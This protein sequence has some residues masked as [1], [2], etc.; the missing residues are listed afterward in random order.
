[1]KPKRSKIREILIWLINTDDENR[2]K[3]NYDV[4]KTIDKA[5]RMILNLKLKNLL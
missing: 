1:M 5:E 4:M 3:I 2:K